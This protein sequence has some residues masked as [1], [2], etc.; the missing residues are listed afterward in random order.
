MIWSHGKETRGES[1]YDRARKI[2][3]DFKLGSP[4][5][6]ASQFEQFKA[7]EEFF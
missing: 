4:K 5:S 7:N 6:F 1:I 2:F 3:E